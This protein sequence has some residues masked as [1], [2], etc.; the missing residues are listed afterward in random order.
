MVDVNRIS[1]TKL[2]DGEVA[3][4]ESQGVERVKYGR[5]AHILKCMY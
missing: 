3:G 5:L 1:F 4:Y 2:S